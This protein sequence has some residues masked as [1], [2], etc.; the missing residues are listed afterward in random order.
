MSRSAPTIRTNIRPTARELR[1][2]AHIDRHGPQS[3]EFLI[4]LTRDTHRCKDTALR[5]LQALRGAGYLFLPPQQKQIAKADFHPFVYDL[6]PIGSEY[7]SYEQPLERHC[8][9]AGH[10][11]H[12]FWTSSVSSAIEINAMQTGLEYIPAARILSIKDSSLAIP[13]STGSVIPDQ[14]FAIK[15]LDGYRAY[16][17]EVDRGTEPMRSNAARKSLQR[18]LLQ[19][20]EVLDQKLHQKHYGLKCN[21]MVSWVFLSKARER[22][23]AELFENVDKTMVSKIF[24][25]QFPVIDALISTITDSDVL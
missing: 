14:L 17:L 19:Y 15:Y 24:E 11:W 5:R 10:W 20:R 18:S 21:L 2:F 4:E 3:S 23:F 6:T 25:K 1:W 16:A 9:P 7:L 22:Q 13:L 12:G 8:R